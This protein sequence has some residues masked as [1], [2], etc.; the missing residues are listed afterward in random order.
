MLQVRK[1]RF[2]PRDAANRKHPGIRK[3]DAPRHKDYYG[4]DDMEQS[5]VLA[6]RWFGQ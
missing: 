6:R 5:C 4:C 3:T 1:G 2:L